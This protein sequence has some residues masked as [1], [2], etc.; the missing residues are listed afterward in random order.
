MLNIVSF[1]QSLNTVEKLLKNIQFLFQPS[2]KR[3]YR[4]GVSDE[5]RKASYSGSYYEAYKAAI[6]N[7]DYDYLLFEN[8]F[9]QFGYELTPGQELPSIRYA[10]YQNPQLYCTYDEYLDSL[11]IMNLITDESNEDIGFHFHEEYQQYLIEQAINESS[12]TIRYDVDHLEYRPLIHSTSHIHIG[13]SNNIRIPCNK[14]IS[15][16]KFSL[17]VIKHIF[18]E[19]WKDFI[20]KRNDTL[21]PILATEKAKCVKLTE[22]FWNHNEEQELFLF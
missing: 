2:I 20:E 1:E 22:D 10:F 6:K 17:F 7:F 12:T 9:F 16:M 3:I 14:V 4:D 8:S 13:H 19:Q 18:Y 21:I 11:R 15:P 5:F